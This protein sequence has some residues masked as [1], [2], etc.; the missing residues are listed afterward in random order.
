MVGL[1]DDSVEIRPGDELALVSEV[2]GV[3]VVDGS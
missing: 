1:I 2:P 3:I